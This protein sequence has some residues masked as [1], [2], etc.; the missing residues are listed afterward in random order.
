M[1]GATATGHVGRR[2]GVGRGD[3][4]A[5]LTAVTA[6]EGATTMEGEAAMEGATA[7]E[8]GMVTAMATVAMDDVVR[9]QWMA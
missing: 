4:D 2:D 3:R 1:D 9:R 8:G 6:M 7:M 5:T